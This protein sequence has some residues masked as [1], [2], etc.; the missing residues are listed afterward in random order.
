MVPPAVAGEVR[1]DAWVARCERFLSAYPA[2]EVKTSSD[3]WR[4]AAR[5]ISSG[6]FGLTL[7]NSALAL[8]VKHFQQETIKT[9]KYK[10]YCS[11]IFGLIKHL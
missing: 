8:L 9:R 6:N 7:L 11:L 4:C 1:S 3:E 5:L 10:R 2:F